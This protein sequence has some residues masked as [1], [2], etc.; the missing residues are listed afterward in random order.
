VNRILKK[1]N[2]EFD[3]FNKIKFVWYKRRVPIDRLRIIL[4]GCKKKFQNHGIE[5]ALIRCLQLEVLP[6]RT[7]KEVELAWVGDFNKKMMAIHQATG[8]RKDKVHRTYR[9]FFNGTRQ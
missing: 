8:A 3:L 1:L 6:R 4:M 2:S 5:S 7:I 9:Y